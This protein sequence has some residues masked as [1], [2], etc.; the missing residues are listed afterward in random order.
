MYH[1]F[2]DVRKKIEEHR[3]QPQNKDLAQKWA[4]KS[5][6]DHVDDW[7]EKITDQDQDDGEYV[8]FVMLGLFD[9]LTKDGKLQMSTKMKTK[10]KLLWRRRV[11]RFWTV[12]KPKIKPLG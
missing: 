8:K 6:N 12:E 4:V 5:V 2:L 10:R 9:G 7:M 1:K 11:I 3:T